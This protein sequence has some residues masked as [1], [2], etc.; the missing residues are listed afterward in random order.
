MVVT[1]G[2]VQMVSIAKNNGVT[3]IGLRELRMTDYTA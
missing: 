3:D 1:I 2:E